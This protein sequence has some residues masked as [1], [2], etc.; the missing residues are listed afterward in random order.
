M[1]FQQTGEAGLS[2]PEMVLMLPLTPHFPVR[3]VVLWL[4]C[5]RRDG[6]QTHGLLFPRAPLAGSCIG[7]SAPSSAEPICEGHTV[8][9]RP[10][11]LH[12]NYHVNG[13]CS[14]WFTDLQLICLV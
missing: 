10:A 3:T 13:A 11:A 1:D 12:V 2:L 14:C 9:S 8:A 7:S 5:H 4:C 6:S